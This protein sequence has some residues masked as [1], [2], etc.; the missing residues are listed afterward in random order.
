MT[1]ID[2][3][4][5]RVKRTAQMPDPSRPINVSP[6][7]PGLRKKNVMTDARKIRHVQ[8]QEAIL[9]TL[10]SIRRSNTMILKAMVQL[11]A[12][13]RKDDVLGEVF[14]TNILLPA[15]KPVL[16]LDFLEGSHTNLDPGVN[17][18]SGD[19]VSIPFGPVKVLL[20]YN[21][22]P[23]QLVKWYSNPRY[24][25]LQRCNNK[26]QPLDVAG[27]ITSR[28]ANIARVNLLNGTNTATAQVKVW[29]IV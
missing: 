15:G 9:L 12:A 13:D 6:L 21:E 5:T 18:A 20:I 23:T 3:L 2:D 29:G 22:S 26:I 19:E 25:N 7:N 16:Q 17:L 14:E 10:E 11:L 28:P 27:P 4:I 8:Y 1:S 24:Q